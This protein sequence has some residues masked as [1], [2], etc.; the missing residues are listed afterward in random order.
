MMPLVFGV[1]GDGFNQWIIA[2]GLCIG[3][4]HGNKVI[5]IKPGYH[6]PLCTIDGHARTDTIHGFMVAH[7]IPYYQLIECH[8]THAQMVTQPAG[9][10]VAEVR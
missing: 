9:L 5:F 10:L 8:T 2:I 3:L 7:H 1:I 6:Q 4:G